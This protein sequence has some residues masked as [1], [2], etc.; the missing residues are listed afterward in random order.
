MKVFNM[1]AN[2]S[3]CLA[4]EVPTSWSATEHSSHSQGVIAD[5]PDSKLSCAIFPTQFKSRSRWSTTSE[6]VILA[7]S[8]HI[9]LSQKFNFTVWNF[10]WNREVRIGVD[11]Y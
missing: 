5:I 4:E 7:S 3:L 11:C 6:I 8:V 10:V 9:F 2:P 1:V